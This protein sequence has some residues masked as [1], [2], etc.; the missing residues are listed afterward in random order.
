MGLHSKKSFKNLGL[1]L[2]TT[3]IA[4]GSYGL[5]EEASAQIQ[6]ISANVPNAH[7][8]E[9]DNSFIT[10]I[11]FKKAIEAGRVGKRSFIDKN[12]V[13]VFYTDRNGE[14]F[15]TSGD[16]VHR[17]A[18]HM[19]K[20]IEESWTHGLNPYKYHY[21]EIY[22][23]L[24]KD[25]EGSRAG[26]ELLLT[27]AFIRYA[28]D[29]SGKRVS[30][31]TFNLDENDW[32]H[33]ISA[34]EA[35]S[36][37]SSSERDFK[38]TLRDLE[39]AGQT[40]QILRKELIRLANEGP[41]ARESLLPIVFKGIMRPGWDH[42]EISRL[43][44]YLG[45]AEPAQGKYVYDDAL[46]SAVMRFQRENSLNADGVIGS[47]T[48]EVIN[49]TNKDKMKQIVANLERLRW[50]DNA[51]RGDKFV[52]VNL[53]SAMLWAIED[54]NVALEMEVIVGKPERR[55]RSFKTEIVG[56]RLN[57]DWTIPPT[58]KR[59][60]ILPK[61]KDDISYLSDKGMELYSGYGSQAVT[62]DPAAIDWHNLS[63]R[64]LHSIRMVQG[65]GDNNP[66]GRYR[67]LMPNDYNIYLHDT[68]HPELFAKPERA[69]SSGCMRMK[70]PEQMASFLL[71]D[72]DGWSEGKTRNILNSYRKTDISI[73]NKVPVYIFYYTV[74]VGD[75]GRIVYGNDIYN[76]DSKLINELRKLD[77]FH[78]PSHNERYQGNVSD[79]QLVSFQ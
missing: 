77:G 71:K 14:T 7:D 65:P 57:P 11:S 74:W 75:N 23:L 66:L 50:V 67:L 3:V 78:I 20:A 17:R 55:T 73:P 28:R 49:R 52:I 37:L 22:D 9:G 47:N 16:D 58:I 63:N 36:Y 24:E 39:P 69:V 12:A 31:K 61:L 44:E 43:R 45:L 29:L 53:P 70:H 13:R 32:K 10:N 1:A 72:K 5:P 54:G 76:Y 40:Y 15:W 62:L 56:V 18:D 27:D 21:P 79:A 30:G 68:N 48:M 6:N 26:L 38:Q 35:V 8:Y 34:M 51:G 25:D 60:D 64:E 2:L 41:H 42:K 19:Y 4:A 46:V 59:Y 33:P